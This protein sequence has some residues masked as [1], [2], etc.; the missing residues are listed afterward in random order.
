M[1][2]IAEFNPGDILTGVAKVDI[3]KAIEQIMDSEGFTRPVLKALVIPE[4]Y[5]STDAFP[6]TTGVMGAGPLGEGSGYTNGIPDFIGMDNPIRNTGKA[7]SAWVELGDTGADTRFIGVTNPDTKPYTNV[8][9]VG[10]IPKDNLGNYDY[11]V[12]AGFPIGVYR[13]GIAP[14]LAEGSIGQQKYL[15]LGNDGSFKQQSTQNEST[16]VAVAYESASDG[17]IFQALILKKR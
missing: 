1:S 5:P 13:G 15:A 14:V 2:Q 8:E 10:G 6:S 11:D 12:R 16:A 17:D 4:T 3:S 9:L 7:P